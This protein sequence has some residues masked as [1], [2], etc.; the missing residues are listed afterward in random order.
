MKTLKVDIC[1]I[2]AGSGGLSVASGAAQ[3]GVKTVLIEE[4]K[5]GGDCLNTGCVPS[6]SLLSAAKARHHALTAKLFGIDVPEARVDFEA[7]RAHVQSVIA[8]IEPN[9]SVERFEGLGVQVIQARAR[10][11]DSKTIVA[12]ETT[13]KARR[14]VVATGS[15]AAIP[16][17]P[18]LADA[19]YL[20]NETIFDIPK[21]P[22]HLVVLGGGPIGVEMAQAF[23]R[24]GSKVS[25]VEGTS[26]LS[27]DDPEL[28]DVV[29]QKLVA[30]GVV[31]HEGNFASSV[32]SAEGRVQVSL[33]GGEAPISGTAL[34]VAAG[35]APNVDDLG[36]EA[37]GV[38]FDRRGIKVDAR[39]RSSQRHIFAIGDV[40][41]G[42]QFTHVAGYHA[43]LVVRNALFRVPAKVDYKAL[44]WVTYTDPELAHVGMTESQARKAHGDKVTVL[45]WPFAENDRAMAEGDT[46]GLLKAFIGPKGR[47]LGASVVGA[48]AGEIIQPWILA[49]SRGLKIGAF[50]SIIAPYP[51]RGEIS[52]RAAGTYYTDTLF[53]PRTRFLV[54]V[55]SWFG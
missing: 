12:G 14:F 5:M 10:F 34:L 35:R 23:R 7:V 4:G 3:L 28:V 36:L 17:V 43:G 1:V 11:I 16:P 55:L 51:T 20:T 18:G 21:L 22:E 48:G 52:K 13:I 44:P 53:S 37:A 19:N 27:K 8:A 40:A 32:E 2:G 9:D 50:T 33:D 41:R 25:V 26:L 29:R 54:K 38:E 46:G 45:S 31:I 42:P 30:E 6:K 24:L 47:I 49:I 15:K 39:L